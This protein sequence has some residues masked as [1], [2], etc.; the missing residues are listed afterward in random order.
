MPSNVKVISGD[1]S[2]QPEILRIID[3]TLS[4]G[5][6]DILI[7]CAGIFA[8]NPITE[9]NFIE[10]NKVMNVNLHAPYLL[11]VELS[12]NMIKNRWGRIVNIGSASS[13]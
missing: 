13:Y 1:I 7:N 2:E 6:I 4:Y 10:Y 3:E 11:S 12:K 8:Q 9:L 5:R